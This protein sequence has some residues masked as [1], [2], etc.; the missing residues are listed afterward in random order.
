MVSL[1]IDKQSSPAKE[2]VYEV[3][4][5]NGVFSPMTFS[6][7]FEKVKERFGDFQNTLFADVQ[8]GKVHVG[9]SLGFRYLFTLQHTNNRL[10]TYLTWKF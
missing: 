1:N 6:K 7:S 8:V 5:P 9:P 10:I 4:G 3:L 2:A